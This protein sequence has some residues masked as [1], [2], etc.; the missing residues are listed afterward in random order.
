METVHVRP[1]RAGTVGGGGSE[2]RAVAR[3]RLHEQLADARTEGRAGGHAL[4]DALDGLA[5]GRAPDVGVLR[6][7][8]AF[9]DGIR[10]V[11]RAPAVLAGVWVLTLLVSLPLALALRGMIAG[12]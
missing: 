4:V 5:A 1:R 10:R 8:R 2:P 12:H 9:A 11:L 3:R 7:I 6:M